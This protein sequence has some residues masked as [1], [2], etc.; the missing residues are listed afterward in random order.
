MNYANTISA[1]ELR[2][3]LADVLDRAAEADEEV[4]VISHSKPKAVLLGVEYFQ[5]MQ[6]FIEDALDAR[7][8]Q[9]ALDEGV[10]VKFDPDKYAKKR[11][12]A[13]L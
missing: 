10:F 8:G 13:T 4:M 11:W 7:L 2:N 5:K 3:N 9:K 6:E 1:T 12:G